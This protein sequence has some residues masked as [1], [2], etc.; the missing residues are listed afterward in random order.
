LV[1]QTVLVVPLLADAPVVVVVST[2]EVEILLLEALRLRRKGVEALSEMA[3]FKL[4]TAAPV[5]VVTV[6]SAVE[7]VPTTTMRVSPVVLV[8]TLV[9]LVLVRLALLTT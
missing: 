3:L 1:V 2:P 7:E 4:T 6:A 8:V 9:E 5:V